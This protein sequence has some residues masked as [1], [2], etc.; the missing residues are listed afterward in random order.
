MTMTERN[1]LIAA[2]K[3][4]RSDCRLYERPTVFDWRGSLAC[5]EERR[6]SAYIMLEALM[7]E[8]EDVN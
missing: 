8:S 2:V 7:V 6:R 1:V 4:L 5:S 3:V